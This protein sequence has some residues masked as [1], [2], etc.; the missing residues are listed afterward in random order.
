[1]KNVAATNN[2]IS[3][4]IIAI[5][6]LLW[7]VLLFNPGNVMTVEHCHISMGGYSE[8]SLSMLLQMNPVSD[9]MI[10]WTLMVFAMML[11]KLIF[12]IQHIYARSFKSKRL[13]LSLLFVLGYAIVWILMG[14]VMNAII[15]GS[16]LV[17]PM[18]FLPALVV[19]VVAVI[20]Q[21]SPIKQRFL[22]RGHNHKS[23]AAF[24]WAANRDAFT[25]G[26]EHGIWCVCSGWALM[27]FPMLLP[28][29][30]H[31]AMLAVT[32]IMVGEHMDHPRIPT[33]KVDFRLKLFRIF[34]AQT[35]MRL[36]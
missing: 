20:W 14:F 22:N 10:G 23:I 8:A 25:F 30:H 32:V 17:L 24:G 27:L 5:S 26:A 1:M 18:S 21:F 7:I 12:P 13:F 15:L 4:L 19:G 29:G 16:N 33:W 28:Q 31:I 9:M 3:M 2:S 6:V 34:F 11:P 35:R 36:R